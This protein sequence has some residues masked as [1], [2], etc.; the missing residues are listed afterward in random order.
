MG[1]INLRLRDVESPADVWLREKFGAE[2]EQPV[3]RSLIDAV[4]NLG[5]EREATDPEDKVLRLTKAEIL[6]MAA[7][8]AVLTGEPHP[9]V[10]VP[11][12]ADADEQTRLL[13]FIGRHP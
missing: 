6:E 12:A 10:R 3:S 13:A 9:L 5:I 7:A 4:L 11:V 8:V 1:A 2:R